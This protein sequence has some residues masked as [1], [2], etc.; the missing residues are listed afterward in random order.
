MARVQAKLNAQG[1]R[2]LKEVA[3]LSLTQWRI[4]AMLGTHGEMTSSSLSREAQ[5]DKGLLSRKLR[6]LVDEG[7]VLSTP[8]ATDRR[9]Q[10]LTLT[11][12]G[13]A[14]FEATLPHTR[15]RQD[16]LRNALTPNELEVLYQ[17]LDKI[18]AAVEAEA[19][20]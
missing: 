13:K 11:P 2:L 10:Q 16:R 5:I 3:G 4:I 12:A 19:N 8:H 17:A 20:E 1:A 7:L 9:V 6:S 15:A 14:V 18:E